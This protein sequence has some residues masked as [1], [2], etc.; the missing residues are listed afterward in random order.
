MIS[1]L[2][3][4]VQLE[5]NALRVSNNSIIY[6][7]DLSAHTAEVIDGSGDRP[8]IQYALDYLLEPT[9]ENFDNNGLQPGFSQGKRAVKGQ[10][11]E[12]EVLALALADGKVKKPTLWNRL[13][14][15]NKGYY[16]VYLVFMSND[17]YQDY[18]WYRR[19][20]NGLWSHKPGSSHAR[21][22]DYSNNIIVNPAKADCGR[23]TQG[24]ILLWV[25][26]KR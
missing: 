12:S 23:Y 18:H 13:I 5:A 4:V 24:G 17:G 14:L 10:N 7:V 2:A 1:L 21:N 15:G 26:K 6:E 16:E 11:Y 9:V 3:A 8:L 19:D 22:T 25:R 20:R